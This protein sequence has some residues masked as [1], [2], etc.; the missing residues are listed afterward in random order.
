MEERVRQSIF[1]CAKL[2]PF[3]FLVLLVV[4]A[5]GTS[6]LAATPTYSVSGTVTAGDTGVPS[7]HVTLAGGAVNKT[8]STDSHG[9]YNFTNIAARNYTITPSGNGCTFSPSEIPVTIPAD[10]AGN[11]FTV[12]FTISGTVTIS[13]RFPERPDKQQQ[14][15]PTANTVSRPYH[16]ALIR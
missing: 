2:F 4:C 7:I 3:V 1:G 15:M 13:L 5:C 12:T 10:S 14:R 6:A 9:N 16:R 11:A 8:V